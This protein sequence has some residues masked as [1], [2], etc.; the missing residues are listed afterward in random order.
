MPNVLLV[1]YPFP[2]SG[3][4]GVPRA[5][6]YIRHLMSHGCHVSV[7]TAT[8]P[9]TPGSDQSLS[10]AIQK[11][12]AVHRA[13][14][15]ELPFAVRDRVWKKLM[16][17]VR[18]NSKAPQSP[19]GSVPPHRRSWSDEKMRFVAQSFFFPDPQRTWVP[20][21]V[22][23]ACRVIRSDNIDTV[24]LNAP[25]FSTLKIGIALKR[26][27]PGLKIITDF[28][29]EWL[30]YYLLNIDDPTSDKVRKAHVLEREIVASSSYVSTVTRAWA[31]RLRDRY[32]DERAD[33][34]IYTPNGYEP[35]MFQNF[36]SRR[37][38]D[39]KMRI[40][41]FGSVHMNR[42][43]SPKNYLEAI[44]TMPAD[45]RDRI[46]TRFIGRVRPDAE[47]CLTNT[48]AIVRKLGFMSRLQGI[49]Y[50]EETDVLLLIATDPTSHAGKLFD[51]LPTGKPILALSPPDGEIGKL[52]QETGAGWCVDPWDR[53][54]IQATLLR[55]FDR[56]EAGETL[57][58][59]NWTAISSYSW[60][61]I[62][63][64]FVNATRIQPG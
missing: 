54:E 43:Y 28:R 4:V 5:L 2:P 62:F 45:V 47:E 16:S 22:R 33:K 39:G 24:I 7:L 35:E 64:N 59:P 3:T 17:L 60:P 30:E 10:D 40:T 49:R 61:A 46:E 23:K 37:L 53:A 56:L 32:P 27:F 48:K 1:T 57:T 13:W 44:E 21:A 19:S 38:S 26:Q 36:C 41:Y 18:N 8:N 50:L 63:A 42:I 9:Q 31:Q 25:P 20:F 14:N 51:Y 15:P 6:A 12:V 29:D 11:D 34:F 52:L 55:I 58:T